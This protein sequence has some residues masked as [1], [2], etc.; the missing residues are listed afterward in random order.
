MIVTCDQCNKK[1]RLNSDSIPA[2]GGA[3]KCRQCAHTI[4]VQYPAPA[5][6]PA[7]VNAARPP[8]T[9]P[10][11]N[12]RLVCSPSFGEPETPIARHSPVARSTGTKKG[13]GLRGKMT[14]LFLVIPIILIAAASSLYLMQLNTLATLITDESTASIRTLA[15]TLMVDKARSVAQQCSLYLE[16]HANLREADLY[17]DSRFRS[18]AVQKLG[19]AGYTFLYAKPDDARFWRIWA[20]PDGR[21]VG[22]GIKELSESLQGKSSRFWE[23]ATAV[24]NGRL[25]QGYYRS[26]DPTGTQREKF[27]VCIAVTGTPYYVAAVTYLDEF[28]RH[29]NKLDARA[30]NIT[31]N[32]RNT[33][34]AIFLGTILLI[35]FV[36]ALYGNSLAGRI[37]SLTEHADLISVGELDA[38]LEIKS[39]DEIGE[40]GEAIS[41]LQDSARLSIRKLRQKQT[42]LLPPGSNCCDQTGEPP[43]AQQTDYRIP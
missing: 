24:K 28:T 8:S 31:A 33:V 13:M 7:R 32:I 38:E 16:H 26:A 12:N 21:V 35:G 36:V 39:K 2:K 3:F 42:H 15:A 22:R 29:I 25:S 18:M 9:G 37:K 43:G 4:K 17:T 14:F 40:L 10:F 19:M 1:Y 11:A 23:I 30:A 6:V 5:P 41:R 20:H 34:I 27:M